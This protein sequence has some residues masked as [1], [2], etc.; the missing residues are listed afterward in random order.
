M[1]PVPAHPTAAKPIETVEAVIIRFAGD[2]GDGIQLTGGQFTAAAAEAGNDTA[3]FPDFPAEIR[4]PAGTPAGVSGFQLHFAGR[5]I[6]T[7]GDIADVL[8]VMNPAALA[9]NLRWL[10]RH[11]VLIANADAFTSRNLAMAGYSANPLDD[12]SLADHQL[13]RVDLSRLTGDALAGL[14][15]SAKE[16]ERCKNYFALGLVFW[17]FDRDPGLVEREIDQKFGSKPLL[18]Q[19]N[20]AVF[21]AGWNYG[22]NT[23]TFAVRYRVPAATDIAAGRYR[24]ISGNEGIALG[25]VAAA[26]KAGLGLFFGSYPITPASDILHILAQYKEF[27]VLT[28]QAEDEIAAVCAAIGASFANQL[29]ATAT[30]GPGLALKSE[31]IG[32]AVMTE[33]PLVVVNVQRGGPST[34]LPTKTEQADLLQALYG[35]NGECP[36]GVLAVRSPA[37]AFDTA[38]EACRV[39]ITSRVPVILLSD[40]AIAN[41]AE[42]WRIPDADA[43]TPIAP[44]FLD[45]PAAQGGGALEPYARDPDTLARPWIKLGTPGL[46]HRIGGI[47]K[48]DRSGHINYDAA[49]HDRMVRL[50]QA[51][52]DAI[53][54]TL[55]PCAVEGDRDGALLVVT[56]GSPWGSALTA[57]RRARQ[58][59]AR[60]GHVQLRWLNPLP[61]DLGEVIARYRRV[62]VAEINGGQLLTLLRARFACDCRG[63]QRVA[64]QP[65][66]VGEIEQAIAA[67]LA[68]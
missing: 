40:G 8:V 58:G 14:G 1:Q 13:F 62:L 47:E 49:N 48:W 44:A 35:R 5:D 26:H 20:R 18:R 22:E 12:G 25:L 28:F 31:A 36:V 56:W 19:A 52:V 15:L 4:A 39:A 33:L 63:Y 38:W 60:V 9:S 32:L 23:D 42:P 21:Q 34:G 2:S 67:A 50:R 46:E 51:K 7:P 29:G 11:G 24:S 57:V 68:E 53:A 16:V 17:L 30:S 64:G 6:L 10:K 27:G 66:T 54:N 3:T 65:L 61:A 37:D 45:D 41:G 55:P 59:G 43:L